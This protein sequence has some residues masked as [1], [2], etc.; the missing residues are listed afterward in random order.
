MTMY[1]ADADLCPWC[2][3]TV[4]HD[5]T[6]SRPGVAPTAFFSCD[7]DACDYVRWVEAPVG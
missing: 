4:S 3:T 6:L 1:Q 7:S 5:Y 2:G